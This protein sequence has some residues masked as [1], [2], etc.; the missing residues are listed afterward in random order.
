MG[1]TWRIAASMC[2]LLTFLVGMSV[3]ARTAIAADAK[4]GSSQPDATQRRKLGVAL[5]PFAVA[6]LGAAEFSPGGFFVAY[7]PDGKNLASRDSFGNLRLWEAE[8]GREIWR[9][10]TYGMDELRFSPDGSTL[11]ECGVSSA[12]LR[13]RRT[14]EVI[15][16]MIVGSRLES[17]TF[18]ADGQRIAAGGDGNV[19]VWDLQG[20]ELFHM[21]LSTDRH[22]PHIW[23]VGLSPDGSRLFIGGPSLGCVVWDLNARGK[24]T[25]IRGAVSFALSPD[26]AL[27]ALQKGGTVGLYDPK[28][29]Q[30]IRDFEGNLWET[31][32]PERKG[33]FMGS[34]APGIS[35]L[36]FSAKGNL[37]AGIS[38]GGRALVWGVQ[39]GR[40]VK[41]IENR[42][43]RAQSVAISPDGRS[44]VTA[45]YQIMLW[46]LATGQPLVHHEGH[47]QFIRFVAFSPDGATLASGGE[48]DGLL[49][50]DWRKGKPSRWLVHYDREYEHYLCFAACREIVA[51]G[52]GYNSPPPN[53]P[54]SVTLW[55]SAT[56]EQL[57]RW[58]E[59]DPTIRCIAVSRD[60]KTVAAGSWEGTVA[61]WN[62][63][64][65]RR[66]VLANLP[67][68]HIN[69]LD[70]SPDGEVVAAGDMDGVIRRWEVATGKEL[71]ELSL[72]P[73]PTTDPYPSI[74]GVEHL[75]F[76]SDGRLLAS[77]S[78]DGRVWLYDMVANR[79]LRTFR[80]S[81]S[82]VHAVTFAQKDKV[83]IST[84]EDAAIRFWDTASDKELRKVEGHRAPIRALGV[85]PDGQ[86]LASGSWDRTILVWDLSKIL[87]EGEQ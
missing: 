50:W 18:S 62:R 79:E 5:P 86:F 41:Q 30:P 61:Q 85:S 6:R 71:K 8:T 81:R 39:T 21:D 80:G 53:R 59:P 28:S 32:R 63:Q 73:A 7:S 16:R 9:V 3:K 49:L 48:F 52:Y 26:G 77:G 82:R 25:E 45:G 37:L 46:D 2:L 65:G 40:L 4:P 10:A 31:T 58:T 69:C 78:H 11:A 75:A 68:V 64:S 67:R 87:K 84:G 33:G 83:V 35:R 1:S 43:G 56:G 60:G 74:S 12:C 17:I 66:T 72:P 55:N 14:G 34:W 20:K 42:D 38:Y 27:L 15:V 13:S 36:S 19:Y 29:L 54:G 76:S 47:K 24:Q 70:F 51:A 23:Y 57:A 44:V 22:K